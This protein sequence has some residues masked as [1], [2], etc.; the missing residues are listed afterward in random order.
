MPTTPSFSPHAPDTVRR[1]PPALRGRWA[2]PVVA[3]LALTL[4]LTGCTSGSGH[5]QGQHGRPASKAESLKGVCPATVTVQTGWTPQAEDG[6]L[7]RLLGQRPGGQLDVDKAHK[8]VTGQLV[9]RGVDTGIRLQIRSGGPAINN[10]PAA[11]KLYEDGG[12]TAA[13]TDMDQIVQFDASPSEH[14]PVIAVFAPLDVSPIVLMWSKTEHPTFHTPADIAAAGERVLYYPGSTYMQFML[15]DGML[16]Q[17]QVDASYTG[18]PDQFLA[19]DGKVV[20]EGYLTNEV[21]QYAH[22]LPQWDKPIG[23]YLIDTAGYRAYVNTFVIRTGDRPRLA[24]CLRRL[25]PALQRATVDYANDPKAT[26]DLIVR[27]VK[28]FGGYPY[29]P[30]RAAYAAKTMVGQGIIGNGPNRTVGDFDMTRLDRFIQILR[31]I[32]AVQHHPIPDGFGTGDV[33]TNTFIDFRI[34]LRF[35]TRPAPSPT[36]PEAVRTTPN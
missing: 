23:W 31:P 13:S 18:A 6:Y 30:A 25:V 19:S 9:D 27:L 35:P 15:G 32:D 16:R 26:N 2:R 14:T 34:G 8:T 5:D 1:N 3:M 24:P 21:F 29:T 28:D 4:T 36:S 12:I 7:Y 33:A 10:T 22:E 11:K 17:S 20:Q